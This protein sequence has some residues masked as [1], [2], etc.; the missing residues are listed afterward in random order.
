MISE[1]IEIVGRGGEGDIYYSHLNGLIYKAIKDKRE[2]IENIR[3]FILLSSLSSPFI[4]ECKCLYIRGRNIRIIETGDP[5]ETEDSN[6]AAVLDSLCPQLGKYNL[7]IEMDRALFDA[8]QISPDYF[9]SHS[10]VHFTR[11]LLEGLDYLQSNFIV[12]RDLKP[13]NLL[14]YPNGVKISDFGHSIHVSNISHKR[15]TSVYIKQY[16]PPEIFCS[17]IC[18]YKSDTWALGCC[19]YRII[20]GSTISDDLS[21]E[22]GGSMSSED[23]LSRYL[24]LYHATSGLGY[25][26][27]PTNPVR[28]DEEYGKTHKRIFGLFLNDCDGKLVLGTHYNNQSDDFSGA[29]FIVDSLRDEIGKII[30]EFYAE[31]DCESKTEATFGIIMGMTRMMRSER[32]SPRECL[33]M[34]RGEYQ[35]N[36][37]GNLGKKFDAREDMRRETRNYANSPGQ[38]PSGMLSTGSRELQPN[39]IHNKHLTYPIHPI[40]KRILSC[41][42]LFGGKTSP[43]VIFST[44]FL[45]RERTSRM[46]RTQGTSR[47][48]SCPSSS[49]LLSDAGKDK[50]YF[51]FALVLCLFHKYHHPTGTFVDIEYFNKKMRGTG[52]M[53]SL[54]Y[55]ELNCLQDIIRSPSSNPTTYI[56]FEQYL[57]GHIVSVTDP[58]DKRK[59][60][61]TGIRN[62]F[63]HCFFLPDISNKDPLKILQTFFGN[64]SGPLL[65][66]FC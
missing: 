22:F 39:Q 41:C 13:S 12:H 64:R 27:G 6:T 14:V 9:K 10:L 30:C 2:S 60:I 62:F 23:I 61:K 36:H 53:S 48:L 54:T 45:Y 56:M 5:E 3:E 29:S 33:S 21:D 24:K 34:I 66:S 59:I 37:K 43:L 32:P 26:S 51:P 16:R 17:G 25:L 38:E 1:S 4:A 35:E 7:V 15:E 28:E 47:D 42:E 57:T 55:G 19:L 49:V 11:D 58:A 18:D 46:T 44:L 20:M 31:R 63:L 8:S 40:T 65:G 52:S 50:E